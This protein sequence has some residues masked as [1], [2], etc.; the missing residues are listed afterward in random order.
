M[1]NVENISWY[2]IKMFWMYGNMF[3]ILTNV[4]IQTSAEG[5]IFNSTSV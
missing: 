1:F 2:S 5:L 4:Y 3:V